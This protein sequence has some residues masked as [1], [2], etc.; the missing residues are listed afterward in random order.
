VVTLENRLSYWKSS[1]VD[2]GYQLLIENYFEGLQLDYTTHGVKSLTS[3][4]DHILL[5]Q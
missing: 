2:P 1:G 3:F 4:L 5:N